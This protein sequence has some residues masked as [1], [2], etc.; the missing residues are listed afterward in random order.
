M[1]K[2][3]Q[4]LTLKDLAKKT[5]YLGY[6]GENIHTQIIIDCSEVFWDYPD[7]V[8]RLNVTPPRGDRYPA[9]QLVKDGDNL[10]WTITNSD[11]IY[12]GSGRIQLRFVDGNEVIKTAVGTTKIDGSIETTGDAPAPLEDWMDRAEETA[13]QIAETAAATVLENYNE[14]VDDVSSLK[15]AFEQLNDNVITESAGPAHIVSVTDGADGMPMRQVEVAIEPVQDLNGYDSPWPA[16]GGDNI[17][18]HEGDHSATA[19]GLTATF[20]G[21]SQTVS[22]T[23]T[24][25]GTS[26]YVL[27]NI[28]C[29]GEIPRETPLSK[30]IIDVPSGI[31]ANLVYRKNGAWVAVSN[32]GVIPTDIDDAPINFQVGILNT[33]TT[34]NVSDLHIQ[35]QRGSTAP[36][37]YTPYSNVCPITG[38]TGAKVTRTGINIWDEKWTNGFFNDNGVF[39]QRNDIVGSQN[40][41]A[42]VPGQTYYFKLVGSSFVTFWKS[43]VTPSSAPASEFISRMQITQNN[44]A[45]TIPAGCYYVHFNCPAIYGGTYQHDIS[46]NYPATDTEY[47]AYQGQTYEVTFPSEAGTVYGGTLDVVSGKLVVDRA[48]KVIDGVN[49]TVRGNGT[50]TGASKAWYSGATGKAYGTTNMISNLFV[51]GNVSAYGG[52]FGRTNS[53][54]IEFALPPTVAQDNTALNAWFAQNP[55]QLCYELETPVVIENLTV[56][57]IT[58]LLGVNNVWSDAGSTAIT[59]PADTKRYIDKK[60]AELQAL[61][62]EN[63]G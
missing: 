29:T 2:R 45:V 43:A 56:E 46:I 14:L 23:G 54:G 31:Y 22:I 39:T 59:Y 27:I 17:F 30:A 1:G 63:N 40:P 52:M 24:N 58:T 15:S 19:N 42:V 41:I 60:I 20:D 36:T 12:S 49:E 8:P 37:T 38:W 4:N 26:A 62:L 47:H 9:S 11:I 10:I 32:G 21:D 6:V 13:E 48:M 18:Y 5:L 28:S 34:L 61:I 33:V 51:A 25:T 3:I 55:T 16:G 7:A 57:Q 35:I 50:A 53:I 44:N